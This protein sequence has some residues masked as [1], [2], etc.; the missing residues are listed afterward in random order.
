[1]LFLHTPPGGGFAVSSSGTSRP[2]DLLMRRL[3]REFPDRLVVGALNEAATHASYIDLRTMVWSHHWPQE[4]D[5]CA[6]IGGRHICRRCLVLYPV[7]FG[8]LAL[9]LLGIHWPVR[10][11]PVAFF[12]LPLPVVIDFIGEQVGLFRYSPKR[13]IVMTALAAPALGRSLDRYLHHRGDGSFWAMVLIYGG[14]CGFTVLC[15]HIREGRISRARQKRMWE[16]DPMATGFSSKE[17]F[18]AYL[19]ASSRGV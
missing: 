11:D 14:L 3:R 1:M 10:L 7:T 13:Q 8:V 6:V 19:D 17:E 2:I 18:E 15:R 12:M 16:R 4:L 9:S 5:R